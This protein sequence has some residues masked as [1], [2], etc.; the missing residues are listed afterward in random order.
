M[1]TRL[2]CLISF[3]SVDEERGAF[4]PTLMKENKR[5]PG[6]LTELFFPGRHSGV[7]GGEPTE[8]GLSDYSLAWLVSEIKRR[9]MALKFHV[10]RLEEGTVDV[11]PPSP[12]SLGDR[13]RAVAFNAVSGRYVR[14]V[15]SVERCDSSVAKR[16]ALQPGWRP[17]ALEKT[18]KDLARLGKELL[19][20]H[21]ED[22]TQ[23]LQEK[24]DK[25]SAK[26]SD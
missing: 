16:Y 21:R 3:E 24:S 9:G 7:G 14:K 12:P 6:Q 13:A 17:E 1:L 5:V 8:I 11:P 2:Y 20:D 26:V 19:S 4:Q 18:G 15:D 10:D 23:L 22:L 25:E